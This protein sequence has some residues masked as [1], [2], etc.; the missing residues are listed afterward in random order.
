MA[1]APHP[2]L[3]ACPF[4]SS[5]KKFSQSFV[6]SKPSTLGLSR[7]VSTHWLP[8]AALP[9]CKLHIAKK[10]KKKGTAKEEKNKLE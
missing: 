4:F 5:A 6:F 9:S 3:Y 7:C 2:L 1:H 8:P 10:K